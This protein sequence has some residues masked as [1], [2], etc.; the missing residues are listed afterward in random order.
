MRFIISFNGLLN[1]VYFLFLKQLKDDAINQ[2]GLI[3]KD[4]KRY[5]ELLT[6]LIAQAMF[7]LIESEVRIK[8]REKDVKLVE[9][10]IQSAIELYKKQLNRDIKVS[11]LDQYLPPT[12]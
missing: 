5:S 8:C 6:N 11:L 10:A 2:L 1:F 9:R 4:E 12:M 3:S 7:Q